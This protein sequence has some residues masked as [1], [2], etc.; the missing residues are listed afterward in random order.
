MDLRNPWIALYGSMNFAYDTI[1]LAHT[2]MDGL[3]ISTSTNLKFN[4]F[5]HFNGLNGPLQSTEQNHRLSASELGFTAGAQGRY[6][7]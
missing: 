7:P 4:I 1:Q 6:L 3:I 2:Y 5:T